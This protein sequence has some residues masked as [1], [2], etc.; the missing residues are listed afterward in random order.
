[1][2]IAV[3]VGHLCDADAHVGRAA[4]AGIVD[5]IAGIGHGVANGIGQAGI[6]VA[7]AG[8]EGTIDADGTEGAWGGWAIQIGS[9]EA[10]GSELY[11]EDSDVLISI[12][13]DQRIGRAGGGVADKSSEI[14]FGR[15]GCGCGLAGVGGKNDGAVVNLHPTPGRRGG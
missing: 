9:L 13:A 11:I 4:N 1:M 14:G 12:E 15:G 10:G 2:L 7:Y 5:T 3:G 8:A 6:K